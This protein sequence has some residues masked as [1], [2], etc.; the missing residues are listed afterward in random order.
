MA[1]SQRAAQARVWVWEREL[2]Q[3]WPRSAVAEERSVSGAADALGNQPGTSVQPRCY[4]PRRLRSMYSARRLSC[5][6]AVRRA[7]LEP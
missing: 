3:E 6:A 7:L 5:S 4:F 1:R 2:V